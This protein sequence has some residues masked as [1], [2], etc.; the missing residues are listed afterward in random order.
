MTRNLQLGLESNWN[1]QY[2]NS[3]SGV[4]FNDAEGNA[5]YTRIVEIKTPIVFDKPIIAVSINTAVP[6]GRIWNYAGYLSRSVS[7]GL[8][9]SFTGERVDLFLGKFNLI[10]FNDL[11]I[12]YFVSIQVPKWFKTANIAIY[13][14][15][16]I[17]TTTLEED[18]QAI[19]TSLGL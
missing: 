3:F 14:Y 13:Q 15:E 18:I 1:L 2:S 5:V 11:N 9:E 19:K 4:I 6:V 16:G 8:G 7:T 17:D 12:N 10:V